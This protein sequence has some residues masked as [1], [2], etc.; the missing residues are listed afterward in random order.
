MTPRLPAQVA[1]LLR[2]PWQWQ[3]NEAS[4]WT[5]RL[6]GLLVGLLLVLPAG[7]ALV[8]L[9]PATGWAAVAGLTALG[10]ALLWG[11]QFGALLRLDHPHT[12]HAVPGQ[13]LALRTA[14]LGLWL[15][16]VLLAALATALGAAL[17]GRSAAASGSGMAIG[18][19]TGM[20]YVALA[21]RWWWAWL[22]LWLVGSLGGALVPWS[23]M[24]QPTGWLLR[25]WQAQPL[26]VTAAVLLAQ[27][28]VLVSLFGSGD[29]HHAK[30]Y[31]QRERMRSITAAGIAGQKPTLA[32]YG[33]WGERLGRP[34]QCLADAWL[35]HVCRRATP[36]PA[37]VMARAEVVL[38]GAQ[39][40]VRHLAALLLVQV[41]LAAVLGAVLWLAPVGADA[42]FTHGETGLT[43]GI[44]S[45]ALSTV[46]SLPGALWVSRREQAL[47]VLLPGMP[48]GAALNRAVA[49]RQLRQCLW[50]CLGLLPFSVVLAW[51]GLGLALLAYGL[52]VLPT[53]AWMWRD[54]SR[55]QPP[56]AMASV[57]P[58]V[59]C[60]LVG[61]LSV[62]ALR[63]WPG[64]LWPWV[65]GML[66]VT[67]GLLAWRWRRLPQQPQALPAGRLA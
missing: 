45:M 43:I 39:H 47:L 20:L 63:Q 8:W 57:V 1:C 65:M 66:L 17:L 31:R 42:L 25:V 23:V 33:R 11:L 44:T 55:M 35:A 36:Q 22:L 38:H 54:P 5:L 32:A 10:M 37:S 19:A 64:L 21:L 41:L 6:Y 7:L 27:G 12:A 3:R 14:A 52:A 2:A 48:Q 40:W 46:V 56:Q 53:V 16:L 4:L 13:P 51:N 26:G 50:I 24:A 30:A 28:L 59:L 58:V 49:W 18:L 34:H 61:T 60:L 15:G 62:W 29:A 67:A 9:P